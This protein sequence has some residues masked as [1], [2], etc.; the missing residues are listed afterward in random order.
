MEKLQ[1]ENKLQTNKELEVF[2]RTFPRG[3][4][5][6][7]NEIT[8]LRVLKDKLLIVRAV[9]QGISNQLFNE[10]KNNSPYSELLSGWNS[11]PCQPIGQLVGDQFVK[12]NKYAVLK[13]P[14]VVVKGEFNFILN[15]KHKDFKKIKIAK[16]EPFP[17]DPRYF[18]I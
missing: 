3:R 2:I 18:G 15:P 11:L 12:E 7:A 5:L 9:R 10:I 8:Y 4:N 1:I 16:T 13:V 6:K 14:S 17:F